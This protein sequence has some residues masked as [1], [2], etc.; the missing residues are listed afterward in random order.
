MVALCFGYIWQY[1][2]AR[3][4]YLYMC[5]FEEPMLGITRFSK[6]CIGGAEYGYVDSIEVDDENPNRVIVLFKTYQKLLNPQRAIVRLV[7]KGITGINIINISYSLTDRPVENLQRSGVVAHICSA[8]SSASMIYRW[9]DSVTNGDLAQQT[10]SEAKNVLTSLNLF[11]LRMQDISD[12]LHAMIRSQNV[13]KKG[14]ATIN[15][16]Y[17]SLDIMNDALS[18]FGLL[19]KEARRFFNNLS[20]ILS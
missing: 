17:S 2:L 16:I 4:T 6:V 19:S 9:V 7:P 18:E 1:S 13:K 11:V 3:N 12:E 20:D 10:V 14:I 5:T 8:P 15:K